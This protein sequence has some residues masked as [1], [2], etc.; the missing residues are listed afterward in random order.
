MYIFITFS[1]RKAKMIIRWLQGASRQIL[2]KANRNL[3]CQSIRQQTHVI[4]VQQLRR[5]QEQ[6]DPSIEYD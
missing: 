5:Y 2:V 4:H 1:V 3:P 6:A